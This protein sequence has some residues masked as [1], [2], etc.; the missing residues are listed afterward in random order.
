MGTTQLHAV[1]VT[2]TGLAVATPFNLRGLSFTHVG[3]TRAAFHDG[4]NASAPLLLAWE[5]PGNG[6]RELRFQPDDLPFRT[7]V[8]VVVTT[9]GS[10]DMW[11][12]GKA[13]YGAEG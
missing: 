9:A 1:H 13:L 2:E 3:A 6:I 8:W 7:S 4:P 11:L 10:L 5:W 12:E